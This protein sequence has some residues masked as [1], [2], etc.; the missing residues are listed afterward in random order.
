MNTVVLIGNLGDAP[1]IGET[2]TT[3]YAYLSLATSYR[4]TDKGSGE[5]KSRTDWHRVVAFNGLAKSLRNL[6]KGERIAV[7]GRLQTKSWER[8]GVK[9]WTVEVVAAEVQ[10]L[11][12]RRQA[13][14]NP[15]PPSQD[16]LAGYEGDFG[17][18]RTDDDI[19]F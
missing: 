2:G 13:E 11:T 1:T 8:D 16:E 7:R 9:H 17:D 14:P 4:Y 15:E 12:P 6:Q 5:V 18:D 3:T 10:F 19:P